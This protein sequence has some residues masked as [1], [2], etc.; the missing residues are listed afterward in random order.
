MKL[1]KAMMAAVLLMTL[2]SPWAHALT[3]SGTI[4]DTAAGAVAGVQVRVMNYNGLLFPDFEIAS[5][6]T[7]A[8]GFYTTP[9][10]TAGEDVY[11]IVG[12]HTALTGPLANGKKTF[13]DYDSP[14][15]PKPHEVSTLSLPGGYVKDAAAPVVINIPTA[16]GGSGLDLEVQA[17]QH[18]QA[19]LDYFVAQGITAAEWK[20]PIDLWFNVI[21]TPTVPIGGANN[22]TNRW[23]CSNGSSVEV[24][25][26]YIRTVAMTIPSIYHEFGHVIQYQKW[27]HYPSTAFPGASHRI[28]SQY[29]AGFA[30][31]EAWAELVDDKVRQ[32]ALGMG[33]RGVNNNTWRGYTGA[34]NR[35][36]AN[37][38]G[39]DFNG[40]I[41]EGGVLHIWQQVAFAETFKIMITGG[42]EPETIR[43]FAEAYHTEYGVAKYKTLLDLYAR[44]G[45]VYTRAKITGL[46]GSGVPDRPAQMSEGNHLVIG[47]TMFVRGDILIEK[48][49][50]SKA[51]LNLAD[52]STVNNIGWVKLGV[53]QATDAWENAVFIPGPWHMLATGA[54]GNN[55][56]WDTR[57]LPDWDANGSADQDADCDLVLQA[58]D[59]RT[60]YDP[61]YPDFAGDPGPNK[62]GTINGT[63]FTEKWLKYQ[64]TWYSSEPHPGADPASAS[65]INKGKV[66]VDNTAPVIEDVTPPPN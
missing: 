28:D 7:N 31:V 53:K 40:E 41:V 24:G 64:G 42:T 56:L 11:I 12:F 48:G 6:V 17:L 60:F 37:G 61:L 34:L 55:Y 63:A 4:S 47:D 20:C 14:F 1:K 44:N 18:P 9:L 21:T 25:T 52:A 27:G 15:F 3:V 57:A 23:W 45:I 32:A 30:I 51:V 65:D 26:N 5:V 16:P 35:P 62:A 49:Q 8:A 13:I 19:I 58:V 36:G 54:Y 43:A 2:S 66:I 10:A 38:S 29:D 33:A 46:V 59:V 50:V 39:T 22:G